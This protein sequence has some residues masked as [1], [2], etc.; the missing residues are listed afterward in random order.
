ML[1]WAS[2]WLSTFLLLIGQ[3]PI[4]V[5]SKPLEHLTNKYKDENTFVL[6]LKTDREA[7]CLFT[8]DSRMLRAS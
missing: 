6:V 8:R 5:V 7:A 4:F 1:A 3:G 2:L